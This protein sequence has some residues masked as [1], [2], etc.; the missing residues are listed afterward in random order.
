MQLQA[1]NYHMDNTRNYT[2]Y[3][4]FLGILRSCTSQEYSQRRSSW[5]LRDVDNLLEPRDTKC[6]VLGRHSGV[7][8]CVE[9][10]L[11]G[12]FTK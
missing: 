7:M 12:W 3:L 10:H 2:H 1:T 9:C 5:F 8:E 11:C 4:G 6:H